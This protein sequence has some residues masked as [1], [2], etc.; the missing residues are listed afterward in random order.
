M[1]KVKKAVWWI[2]FPATFPVEGPD[3]EGFLSAAHAAGVPG[4]V[5]QGFAT[6]QGVATCIQQAIQAHAGSIVLS[7]QD[8]R[9]IVKP[10]QD[11]HKAGIKVVEWT[12]QPKAGLPLPPGIDASVTYDY[13]G[14]G[15]LGG[16]YAV[17]TWGADTDAICITTPEI[18]VTKAVCDGFTAAVKKYCPSCKVI[19]K[20][21][22]YA[23]LVSGSAAVVNAAALADSH[24]NFVE[25]WADTICG[26]AGPSLKSLGKSPSQV[27]CGGQNGDLASLGNTR[28]NGYEYIDVGQDATWA[29]WAMFDGGA[30]VQ[31][32]K[33]P[34]SVNGPGL[35]VF[36]REY[37]PYKGTISYAHLPQ[38]YQIPLSYLESNYKQQW[39]LG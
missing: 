6:P 38:L 22:P 30:R 39:G 31:V 18:L 26:W 37:F 10:L 29:G 1:S 15:A 11:A 35:T 24:L 34:K 17:A 21:V 14:T 13:S 4:H 9:T 7:A 2:A 5:C 32:Q 16:A 20:S 25:G 28:S 33:M 12:D 27:R 8:P 19:T 36:T 23:S 3:A